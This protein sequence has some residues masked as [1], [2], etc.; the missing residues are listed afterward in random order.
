MLRVYENRFVSPINLRIQLRVDLMERWLPTAEQTQGFIMK[1]DFGN[2]RLP[3]WLNS[4][5]YFYNQLSFST[6]MWLF[7]FPSYQNLFVD[8]WFILT[9]K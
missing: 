1:I 8:L 5:S 6:C 9:C 3:L 2:F 7:T 4:S